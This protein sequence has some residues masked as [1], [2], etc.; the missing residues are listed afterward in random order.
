VAGYHH[1]WIATADGQQLAFTFEF[2]WHQG[3]VLPF[4]L[5]NAIGQLMHMMNGILEPMKCKFVFVYLFDMKIN[6]HTPA[7]HAMQV[8]DVRI[9]LTEPCLKAKQATCA[10]A[11]QKGDFYGVD[12]DK[13]GIHTQEYMTCAVIDWPQPENRNDVKGILS[14]TSYDR[15][16]VEHYAYIA[17]PMYVI[18][19]P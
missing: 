12:I 1:I 11:S 9:L 17:M 14:L 18:G 13:D 2:G 15:K 6:S 19:T 4:G 10:W 8:R 7:E 5:V 16:F 3:G